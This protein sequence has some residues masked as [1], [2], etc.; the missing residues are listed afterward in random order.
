MVARPPD[1]LGLP[2]DPQKRRSILGGILGNG[3]EDGP[4]RVRTT[5]VITRLIRGFGDGLM[6][7]I[8]PFYLST[9]GFSVFEIGVIITAM[10]VAA[11]VISIGASICSRWVD[12]KRLFLL[13]ALAMIVSGAAFAAMESFWPL[14]LVALL[15]AMNPSGGDVNMTAP[16]E[17][18]TLT[19]VSRPG[20]RTALFTRYAFVGS[21]ATAAGGL[22]AGLP[23]IV[24][25]E[26]A[27]P[28]TMALKGCF[29]TYAILALLMLVLYAR[30]PI[31]REAVARPVA[32]AL[33]K[34]PNM[35]PRL[36]I[37]LGLD[38][39]GGGFVI[40]S[41]L[42][43]WLSESFGVSMATVATIFF[44]SGLASSASLLLSPV[45]ARRIGLLNVMI[46]TH[47]PA[48]LCLVIVPMM[49]DLNLA[50]ALLMFRSLVSQMDVPVR[51]SYVMAV[52][53]PHERVAAASVTSVVRGL[54]GA[55]SPLLAGSLLAVSSFG[56]PLL[57][58]GSLKLLY[59]VLFLRMF[60]K[61]AL[62]DK[63]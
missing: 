37:V 45:L 22:A 41:V 60:Q 27:V 8:I 63:S 38:A 53:E 3:V 59:D 18:A 34:T 44:F 28:L 19:H 23:Q 16:L 26:L 51:L 62:V 40:P 2:A 11:S 35:L 5:L 47:V 25:A 20:Q 58:G 42:A 43:I 17:Q 15:G 10:L 57:I 33:S 9:L 1:P 50:I 49:T 14:F 7:I 54:A 55:A 13:A 24:A 32:A 39:F 31:S 36:A 48:S 29:V 12:P 46:V 6:S 30:M 52:V 61:V 56:W 4:L 21:V